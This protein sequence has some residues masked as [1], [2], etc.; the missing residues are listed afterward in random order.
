LDSTLRKLQIGGYTHDTDANRE[1]L[2]KQI[3]P[4]QNGK[5]SPSLRG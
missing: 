4:M 3:P 5:R 1:Y 2:Q